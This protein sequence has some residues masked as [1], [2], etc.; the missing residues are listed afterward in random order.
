MVVGSSHHSGLGA[1]LAGS[2][3]RALLQGAPC[4][5]AVAPR[6]YDTQEVDRLRVVGVGFDGTPEAESA[7]DGAID[8]ARAA[9]ATIRV[10]AALTPIQGPY[11]NASR[12]DALRAK[13]AAAVD[14]CPP[15]LRAEVRIR[16]GAAIG[17]LR[18]EADLGIDLL[19]LGSRS[20]GP[21][22]RTMLGSV[23]AELMRSAPCPLLVFPRGLGRHHGREG[24]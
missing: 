1:V 15:E 11:D 8:L 22:L 17:V 4:P 18:A 6:A 21:M 12:Y 14:R 19:L 23:S 5:V 13:A 2:V 7:L 24:R 10:I 20:Y 3:G 9:E 16:N